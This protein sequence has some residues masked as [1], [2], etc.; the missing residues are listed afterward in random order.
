MSI[1]RTVSLLCTV[2][3]LSVLFSCSVKDDE[4]PVTD[5]ENSNTVD[6]E[7]M[8]E[9]EVVTDKTQETDNNNELPDETSDEAPDETPD[10]TPDDAIPSGEGAYKQIGRAS[11]RETV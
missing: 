10:E 5:E 8:D 6:N 7:T 4:T 3:F 11:C 2:L 9:N 1:K